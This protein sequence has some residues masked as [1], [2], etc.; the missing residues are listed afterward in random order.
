M[1]GNNSHSPQIR[2]PY[3]NR[4]TTI[5]ESAP[6]IINDNHNP[7]YS[8]SLIQ[9]PSASNLHQMY[10]PPQAPTNAPAVN[11]AAVTLFL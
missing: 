7:S 3:S 11:H 5:Q 6:P 2:H 1:Y 9:R 8:S 4:S 10:S